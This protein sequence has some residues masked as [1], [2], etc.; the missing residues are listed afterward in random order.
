MSK[1]NKAIGLLRGTQVSSPYV[2]NVRNNGSMN[3][4]TEMGYFTPL[5][6][7]T[8]RGGMGHAAQ[9]CILQKT[10]SPCLSSEG[11]VSYSSVMSECAGNPGNIN[12]KSK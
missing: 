12:K 3:N 7:S 9:C 4:E 1:F 11:V 10:C 8:L 5:V 6:F 2:L